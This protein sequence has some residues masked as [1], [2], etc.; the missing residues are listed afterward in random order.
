MYKRQE[1]GLA[2]QAGSGFDVSGAVG[3]LSYQN[4]RTMLAE[5]DGRVAE[6]SIRV[7]EYRNRV[8]TLKSKV[9]SL[10]VMEAQLKEYTRDYDI[11]KEQ[12]NA[13]LKRR[14]S[15][16]LSGEMENNA[17]DVK[18]KVIDPPF[19]PS[20]PT[21]PNKLLLNTGVLIGAIALAIG[22]G[23]LIALVQPVITSRHRLA[24]VTGLPILG[25][26]SLIE[27][28]SGKR[29]LLNAIIITLPV[30]L[31]LAAF[32]GVNFIEGLLP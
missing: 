31:L 15:A 14:E 25:A 26:V 21:A 22:V 12:Y 5:A 16:H 18:F 2:T 13:L 1:E 10:P 8:K 9:S 3:S 24:R 20:K 19:V 4:M 11:V 29:K 17:D 30:A 6:L 32:A 23:L 27:D 28:V 7:R